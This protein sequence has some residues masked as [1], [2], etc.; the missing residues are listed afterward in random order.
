MVTF[1]VMII[2]NE[3]SMIWDMKAVFITTQK[4]L[5]TTWWLISVWCNT[6]STRCVPSLVTQVMH[7]T[8]TF[9]PV[10]LYWLQNDVITCK[11]NPRSFCPR[12]IILFVDIYVRT[13]CMLAWCWSIFLFVTFTYLPVACF[14][15][16][17]F[18]WLH[19][20][21]IISKMVWIC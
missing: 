4:I 2:S 13:F 11:L 8:K 17:I 7:H 21:V 15:S 1:P 14:F 20:S 9:S 12:S 16:Q 10:F 19:F 6:A 5:C 3:G 18:S